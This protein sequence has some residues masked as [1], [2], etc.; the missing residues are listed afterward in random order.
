[1]TQTKSEESKAKL[2]D[3]WSNL[4]ISRLEEVLESLGDEL[5]SIMDVANNEELEEIQSLRKLINSLNNDMPD[6]ILCCPEAGCGR[7]FK[8]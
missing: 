5:D 4:S 1:M 3:Y 8:T 6:P 7:K 2:S